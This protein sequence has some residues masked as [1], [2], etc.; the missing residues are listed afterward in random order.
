MLAT[1]IGMATADRTR[2][3]ELKRLVVRAKP[4]LVAAVE[5]Y[6]R[7]LEQREGSA[8]SLQRALTKL[9]LAG[10]GEWDRQFGGTKRNGR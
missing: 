7:W 2:V 8:V 6:R 4:E 5:R 9:L 3:A 10:L 1:V